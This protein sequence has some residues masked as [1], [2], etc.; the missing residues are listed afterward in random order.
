M[1][2]PTLIAL[3]EDVGE[4]VAEDTCENP[5]VAAPPAE[6]KIDH[7]KE[8]LVEQMGRM[9][10]LLWGIFSNVGSKGTDKTLSPIRDDFSKI[11]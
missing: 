11:G 7:K 3:E 4:H 6:S 9:C 2:D 8:C 10:F 5:P 1:A